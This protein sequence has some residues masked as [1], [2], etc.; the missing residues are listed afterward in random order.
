VLEKIQAPDAANIHAELVLFV[1]YNDSV[2]ESSKITIV[3]A[4]EKISERTRIDLEIIL[5]S[6]SSYAINATNLVAA[7][8]SPNEA[9]DV[10]TK[11]TST[12]PE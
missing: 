12:T 2:G 7:I 3:A 8:C 4:E 11:V 6:P 9:M 1:K 10:P 5:D